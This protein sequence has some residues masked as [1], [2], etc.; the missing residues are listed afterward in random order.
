MMAKLTVRPAELSDHDA[1]TAFT[2]NTWPDRGGDYIPRVFPEWVE[3]AGDDQQTF[4]AATDDGDVAGILTVVMLSEY[5]AWCQGMR[6]NPDYRGQGVAT[7]VTERAFDWAREQGATVARNMVFSW[8]VMGLGHSRSVGFSPAAEFRWVH[9]E[10]DAD[11]DPAADVTDE[12]DAGWSFWQRSDARTELAG[13]ALDM[14]ESWAVSDLS[15]A[16]LRQAA[17]ETSLLVVQDDGT[18]GLAFRV[19]DYE[20]ENEDGETVHWADYGLGAWAD[21]DAARSVLAAVSRDAGELGVDRT[22]VL[23]PETARVVSDAALARVEVAAEPDF[24]LAADLTRRES[25]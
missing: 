6:T 3:E 8:N 17:D 4:V 1:V 15:R 5:E 16:T 2:E 10:P 7:R 9:P 14:G 24:V 20:R 21:A 25:R 22:R 12:V 19:R 18:E 23:V 11:A 13:L